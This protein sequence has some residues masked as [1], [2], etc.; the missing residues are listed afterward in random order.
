MVNRRLVLV[1]I[2][3]VFVYLII[4]AGV[5]CPTCD[6]PD[7]GTKRVSVYASPPSL[8]RPVTECNRAR[9]VRGQ[10][11]VETFVACASLTPKHDD[12]S[13]LIQLTEDRFPILLELANHWQGPMSVVV[14]LTY[15]DYFVSEVKKFHSSHEILKRYADFHVVYIEERYQYP[16]NHLRNVA[17][18]NARTDYVLTLDVDFIPNPDMHAQL[19]EAASTLSKTAKEVLVIAAFEVRHDQFPPTKSQLLDLVKSEDAYQVH[20]YK[21]VHAHEPTNYHK[22]P[23]A[24]K[25]YE[26]QYG[27]SYEPYFVIRRDLCPLFDERFIGYGNDKSSHTYE[28]AIAGFKFLVL[29]DPFIIHKDHPSPAWRSDQGSEEVWR[30]WAEFTRAMKFKYG[31]TV[32]VPE[33]LKDACNEGDCPQFWILY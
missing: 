15:D 24:R 11:T 29:P 6:C 20:F 3:F 26:V 9:D 13:V 12:V 8:D 33:W 32:E 17:L 21:G 1:L 30:R 5:P 14:Y 18:L 19:K 10:W 7:T 27:Y 16:V 28:V 22:W 23:T 31:N 25:P 2:G 4:S